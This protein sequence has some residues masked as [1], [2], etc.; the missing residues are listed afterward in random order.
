[1]IVYSN[2][3]TLASLKDLYSLPSVSQYVFF[4]SDIFVHDLEQLLKSKCHDFNNFNIL[5]K[6][7]LMLVQ[8]N[9]CFSNL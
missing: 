6:T 2:Y 9:S 4:K 8:W 7:H 5:M 1:M 3:L